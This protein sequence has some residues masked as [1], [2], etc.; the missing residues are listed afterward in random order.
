ME[1]V[2]VERADE[3]DALLLP[4]SGRPRCDLLVNRVSDASPP[5]T[6]KKVS[7]ILALFDLHSIPVINRSRSFFVGT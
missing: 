4:S 6:V 7:A 3:C 2:S 5:P 1:V